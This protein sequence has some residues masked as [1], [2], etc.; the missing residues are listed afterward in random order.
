MD[1]LIIWDMEYEMGRLTHKLRIHFDNDATSCYDRIPCFLVNLASHKYGM[2]KKVSIVQ[3]RL[4]AE[5]KYHLKTTLGI[6]EEFLTHS[7]AFP[8]YGTGQGSGKFSHI[9]AVHQQHPI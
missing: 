8:I 3:G 9:L 7:K 2:H 5:A 4:L 1:P 6:L